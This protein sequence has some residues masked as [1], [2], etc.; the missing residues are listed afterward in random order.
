MTISKSAF[1]HLAF[2]AAATVA[3]WSSA[4]HAA[5]NAILH[6][7]NNGVDSA[8]CG[9]TNDPC[10]SISRAISNAHERDVILVGPGR[11]G[12]VNANGVLGEPGEEAS[13]TGA[14]FCM[15]AVTK[16][17]TLLSRAGAAA[18]I[19]DIGDSNGAPVSIKASH[20][21]F[22]GPFSGFTVTGSRLLGGLVIDAPE[23]VS[24]T[25]NIAYSNGG[26]DGFSAVSGTRHKLIG[27]LS[28][29]NGHGFGIFSTATFVKQNVATKNIANGFRVQSVDN[30]LVENHASGNGEWGFVLDTSRQAVRRNSIVGNA[31]E[32][33][34]VGLNVTRIQADKNNIYG[35]GVSFER[36]NNCG[37][38]AAP[39]AQVDATNN[40]WG[41]ATGP[42]PDPADNVCGS[43]ITVRS[44]AARAFDVPDA[45]VHSW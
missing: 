39:G 21:V 5:G 24:V 34:F 17:L 30:L 8:T 4:A 45:S 10:R 43:G 9:P 2:V 19:L 37:L 20:V 16:R 27:N 32:G 14:C 40:F 26:A 3:S 42:G 36:P 35:N 33:I 13:P 31:L 38:G 23:N 28:T 18:T 25:G 11:Y 22:G 44:F 1:G 15:I 29:L 7:E 6:V 41:S 12:D